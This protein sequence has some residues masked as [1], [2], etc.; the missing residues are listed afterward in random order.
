M[1]LAPLP[2]GISDQWQEAIANPVANILK[3]LRFLCKTGNHAKV[4]YI[5]LN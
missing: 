1:P 2:E 4:A 3:V 5:H